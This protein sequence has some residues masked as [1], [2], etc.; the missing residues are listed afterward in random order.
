MNTGLSRRIQQ[1]KAHQA[2]MDDEPQRLRDSEEQL[3][4][5]ELM[6]EHQTEAQVE[7]WKTEQPPYSHRDIF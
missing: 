1:K 4:V 6:D 3:E 2:G 7:D 5:T